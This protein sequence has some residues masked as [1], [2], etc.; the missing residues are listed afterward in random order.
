MRNRAG[1]RLRARETNIVVRRAEL[2]FPDLITASAKSAGSLAIFAAIRLA[3][4]LLS[5]FAAERRPGSSAKWT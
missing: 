4:S 5:K 1:I 2:Q 3:S